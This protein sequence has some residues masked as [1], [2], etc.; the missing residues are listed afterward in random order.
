MQELT[1]LLEHKFSKPVFLKSLPNLMRK[2]SSSF[3]K[4]QA[5]QKFSQACVFYGSKRLEKA[6]DVTAQCFQETNTELELSDF[7]LQNSK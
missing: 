2:D 7:S 4:G 3:T 1:L 6:S 5:T